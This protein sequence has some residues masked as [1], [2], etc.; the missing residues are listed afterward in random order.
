MLDGNVAEEAWTVIVPVKPLG[1]AKSRLRIDQPSADAWA[2]AFLSD[3]L[4]AV[5]AVERIST[6]I[7]ATSDTEVSSIAQQWGAIVVDDSRAPGINRAVAH[8]ARYAREGS[9]IAVVVS[10]LPLLTPEALTRVLEYADEHRTS[11]LA[12]LGGTGTTMWMTHDRRDLP[13]HFGSHS[14]A[15]HAAAG[16]HDIA[17]YA[18]DPG[19]L[20]ARSDIDTHADLERAGDEHLGPATRALVRSTRLT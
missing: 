3:V 18:Q 11:F 16:A 4:A 6:T 9:G 8:A 12:D 1:E 7:V 19:L 13:P 17:E 10:D 5:S 20:P 2:R 14:R 15:A